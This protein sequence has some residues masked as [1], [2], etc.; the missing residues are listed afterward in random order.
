MRGPGSQHPGRRRHG[1]RLFRRRRRREP[2]AIVSGIPALPHR[3]TL[4]EQAAVR[5]L[6]DLVPQVRRLQE[7]I[8]KLKRGCR[9]MMEVH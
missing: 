1:R 6:P 3:Q 2:K 9:E 7:E 8:D 5:R 4:R